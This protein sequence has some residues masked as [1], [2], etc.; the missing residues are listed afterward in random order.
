MYS[1]DLGASPSTGSTV[2]RPPDGFTETG[3][4]GTGWSL[5]ATQSSLQRVR[6]KCGHSQGEGSAFQ[7]VPTEFDSRC[8]LEV[9]AVVLLVKAL[10]CQSRCGGRKTHRPLEVSGTGS[11]IGDCNPLRESAILSLDSMPSSDGRYT[12][13]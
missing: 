13:F 1:V 2:S 10:G 9:F 5:P 7:A 4:V 12:A 6:A 11:Q 3:S 8:P